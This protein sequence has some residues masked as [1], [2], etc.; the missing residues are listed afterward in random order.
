[1]TEDYY[2]KTEL[3]RAL[4]IYKL[5]EQGMAMAPELEK[6]ICD[7][8]LAR[9][10]VSLPRVM[11]SLR[12]SGAR[13]YLVNYLKNHTAVAV[14][15][16]PYMPLS[17]LERIKD[18]REGPRRLGKLAYELPREGLSG[19]LNVS[20]RIAG[21]RKDGIVFQKILEELA[22]SS[23]PE[24]SEGRRNVDA[25]RSKLG[26]ELFGKDEYFFVPA[27]DEIISMF[28]SSLLTFRNLRE[29]A[30]CEKIRG[31][32]KEIAEKE[33][34][35]ERIME[36]YVRPEDLESCQREE[37]HKLSREAVELRKKAEALKAQAEPYRVE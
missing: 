4:E 8:S 36:K 12:G 3:R 23:G 31:L 26:M 6:W 19:L 33:L 21:W 25:L 10:K 37:I 1:M 32:E 11:S 34:K 2:P 29:E 30:L 9:E 24:G 20:Y 15:Y 7:I 18:E 16:A 17:E 13:I 27:G 28:D 35:V 14:L 5:G 22:C